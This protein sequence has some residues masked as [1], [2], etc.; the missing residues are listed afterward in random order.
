MVLFF[1]IYFHFKWGTS[2]E[3]LYWPRRHKTAGPTTFPCLS[4]NFYH[5]SNIR[6]LEA[7]FTMSQDAGGMGHEINYQKQVCLEA[8]F[9]LASHLWELESSSILS[10]DD[11]REPLY[12][13]QRHKTSL[14]E[15]FTCLWH[16]YKYTFSYW[17]YRVIA[18]YSR[19]FHCKICIELRDTSLPGLQLATCLSH[20]FWQISVMRVLETK[21][22]GHV[23]VRGT[24]TLLNS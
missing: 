24:A 3:S 6:M 8:S 4:H 16:S 7:K 17:F 15:T 11:P 9:Q 2:R 18:F 5:A 23:E 13:T 20:T 21:S 19:N 1:S 14:P 22:R 10:E 12:W